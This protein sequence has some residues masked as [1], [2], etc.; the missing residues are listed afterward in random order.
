M[1]QRIWYYALRTYVWI[2][3][4]FYFRKIIVRGLDNIPK[5]HAVLFTPNHQNAFMDA[6]LVVATNHRYTHFL[7]RADVFKKGFIHWLL[8][9]LNLIPVYRIR[10]GWSSLDKN[11]ESFNQCSACF[12]KGE[13]VLIFPEGNHGMLRRIRPLSKGF[14]RV[15]FEALQKN[16]EMKLSVVPVGL[17]YTHHT[18]FFGSVSIYYGEPIA[19]ADYFK[20]QQPQGANELRHRLSSSMKKLT[21]HVEDEIHYEKIISQ[22]NQKGVDYLNPVAVNEILPAITIPDD[23]GFQPIPKK[24]KTNK[25]FLPIYYLLYFINLPPLLWW[26]KIVSGVKDPVF[27]SSL[28]FAFGIFVFPVYYSVLVS[29]SL[30][31]VNYGVTLALFVI[32]LTSLPLMASLRLGFRQEQN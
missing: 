8:S 5:D 18:S 2:G 1:R 24:L 4:H 9:T 17:N 14:T 3:L 29:L 12:E 19:A 20:Q 21:T 27:I 7:T 30:L 32:C 31:F 6:L 23:F 15:V 28:K 22:L 25:L 11:Q 10:D 13:C 16:P 26:K